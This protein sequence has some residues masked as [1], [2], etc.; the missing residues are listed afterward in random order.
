MRVLLVHGLSRT[1]VSLSGLA[2]QLRWAG[3][4]PS[5]FGYVPMLESWDGLICR[6]R[7]RLE[8]LA[9]ARSDY[10]V[11]G[12]SLG[13]I[14]LATALQQWPRARQ[15]PIHLITLGTPTRVPRL[16]KIALRL[17]AFRFLTG[18]AG[19]K[20]GDDRTFRVL[21]SLPCPW[22][23]ICGSRGWGGIWSPFAGEANDGV[24]SKSEAFSPNSTA[25]LEVHAT[26][27]FMMNCRAV[28]KS[29]L[30]SLDD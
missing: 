8:E 4:R 16:A 29:V 6:L 21:E 24:L 11:I 3:H 23:A 1:S 14:L 15:P 13:G 18:Q 26:H 19:A 12:H 20:L 25:R 22:T 28:H 27:T 30:Q 9:E 10:A 2:L 5:S 17:G 7:Q